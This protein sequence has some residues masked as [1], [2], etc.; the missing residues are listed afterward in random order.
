M[1]A[2]PET[3]NVEYLRDLLY[4]I[5]SSAEAARGIYR[6][7]SEDD[8]ALISN[9]LLTV[10]NRIGWIADMGTKHAG[11]LQCIGGAEEWMLSPRCLETKEANH[12]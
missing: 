1:A 7:G 5:A 11:G 10:I 4:E 6:N 12:V 2:I 8:E 9:A 3:V